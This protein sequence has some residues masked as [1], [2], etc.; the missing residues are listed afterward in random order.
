VRKLHARTSKPLS[1]FNANVIKRLLPLVLLPKPLLPPLLLPKSLLLP[2]SP[3]RKPGP[4][5]LRK[6]L[7]RLHLHHQEQ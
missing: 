3:M 2:P 1:I 6:L 7:L 5:L 4:P